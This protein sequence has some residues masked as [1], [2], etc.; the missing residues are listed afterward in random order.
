M[1]HAFKTGIVAIAIAISAASCSGN[2]SKPGKD[3]TGGAATM[4]D[5]SQTGREPGANGS[6]AGID[7]GIEKSGSGG[8]DTTKKVQ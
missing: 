6:G 3:T 5:S 8:V 2:S 1:K 7:S 4:S